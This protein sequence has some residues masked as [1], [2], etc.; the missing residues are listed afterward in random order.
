MVVLNLQFVSSIWF[1]VL[2]DLREENRKKKKKK[3]LLKSLTVKY[4]RTTL[5]KKKKKIPLDLGCIYTELHCSVEMIQ[6]PYLQ[7]W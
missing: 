5:F 7:K 3:K 6:H 2:F 4:L 1:L